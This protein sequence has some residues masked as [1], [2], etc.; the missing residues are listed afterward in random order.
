MEHEL[1]RLDELIGEIL[2]YARLEATTEIS[3]RK[4]DLADLVQT[5]VDDAD[6][7][8]R[9]S[10]KQIR[11]HGP[12]TVM[13]DVDTGLLQRAVENVVR[14]ALKHTIPQT[15]VEV[16][17]V[18]R[19]GSVEIV[20]RDRGPGVPEVALDK[21]FDAFYR[22]EDGR[23]T[24]SGSG[25]IGLAI[26]QRSIQLHGGTIRAVNCSEGGLRI[27]IALPR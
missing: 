6:V 3:R 19:P 11:L 14:N 20:V 7:E 13:M 4:T 16:T 24:H 25:G 2:S 8:G 9:E 21:L 12:E 23:G 10:G 22:V 5:I 26:A 17:I 15:T 27:E 18:E 1:E